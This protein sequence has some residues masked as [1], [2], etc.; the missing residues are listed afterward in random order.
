MDGAGEP[1][2]D[3]GGRARLAALEQSRHERGAGL[4]ERD[5]DLERVDARERRERLTRT[6]H[7]TGLR[8]LREDPPVEGRDHARRLE[9]D[10]RRAPRRAQARERALE[11]GL[12]RER[13]VERVLADHAAAPER[14]GAL[15]LG[16]VELQ[17]RLG[18]GDVGVGPGERRPRVPV[19][20][21]HQHLALAHPPPVAHGPMELD[22]PARALGGDLH[23]ARRAHEA[24]ADHRH[25]PGAALERH[26]LDRGHDPVHG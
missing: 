2:R 20:Q 22:D 1:H 7:G 4:V 6:D 3:R 25:G 12:A 14:A 13:L 8:R 24:L 9:R 21:A 18:G 10:L 19:V 5:G 15:E 17:A 26:G 11:L 23:L 16:G